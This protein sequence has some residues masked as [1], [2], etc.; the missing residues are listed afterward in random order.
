[1]SKQVEKSHSPLD[2]NNNGILETG[3]LI[4]FTTVAEQIAATTKRLEKATLLGKYF[5]SLSDNDL[6]NAARYFAG[7]IFP[8]RDQRTINIG[9]SAIVTALAA[10]S[11]V[12]K[13]ILQEK[14]VN[15]G[16]RLCCNSW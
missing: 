13:S 14:L 4:R 16:D 1:M 5:A 8:L 15:L 7:Y 6:V 3:A 9:G 2:E 11:G 12:E 10:V